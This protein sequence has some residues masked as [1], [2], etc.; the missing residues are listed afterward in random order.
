M[1]GTQ[2]GEPIQESREGSGAAQDG[3]IPQD[4]M[5]GTQDLLL[6]EVMN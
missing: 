4:K 2:G 1:E 6:R 5:R 3:P